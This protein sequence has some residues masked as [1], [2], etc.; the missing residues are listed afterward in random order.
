MAQEPILTQQNIKA[1]HLKEIYLKALCHNGISRAQLKRE[2]HLSFPSISALVDELLAN[3]ILLESGIQ[4]TLKR[5]RP[6]SILFVNPSALAIPVLSMTSEGYRCVLYDFCA[7]KITEEFLPFEVKKKQ[8]DFDGQW[9]P[10]AETLLTPV[11]HWITTLSAYKLSSFVLCISGNFDEQGIMTS[12]SLKITTPKN[13][14]FSIKETLGDDICIVNN[15]D[16]YAYA[17]K[18]CQELPNDFIFIQVSEGVGAG[19]IRD[20]KIFQKDVMRAGEIGHMSI[21]YHG[22]NCV[23]GGKGC[24]ERYIS[25]PEITE[26]VRQLLNAETSLNFSQVCESYHLGD[27]RMIQLINQKAQLLAVGISNML[28]MQPVQ[29]VIIGGD[30]IMLGEPFLEEVQH[31]MKQRGLRRYMDRVTISYSRNTDNEFPGALWN[32]LEHHLTIDQMICK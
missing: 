21:D 15:A 18:F 31:V 24:L 10:D 28:A 11:K 22:K 6:Q 3:N 5:G 23:C 16:C 17:E 7:N 27:S 29:N 9:H 25:T 13:F 26:D 30:I 2:M 32:Y 1:I 19:I 14:L 4:E 20:G 12:S 8:T